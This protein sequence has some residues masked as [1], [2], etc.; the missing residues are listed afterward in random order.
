MLWV[1]ILLLINILNSKIFCINNEKTI[2][3]RENVK[4]Y[5]NRFNL[6]KLTF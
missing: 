6:A 3:N 2:R 4:L 5:L 1:Y